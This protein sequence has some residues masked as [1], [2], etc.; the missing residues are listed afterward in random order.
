MGIILYY[1]LAII[2]GFA[3]Q[4][5][6]CEKIKH[7]KLRYSPTYLTVIG[8]ILIF[9]SSIGVF[10]NMG[11]SFYGG[12]FVALVFA[13]FFLPLTIGILSA[14]IFHF[15]QNRIKRPKDNT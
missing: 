14:D 4:L 9:L 2:A 15:V 12:S 1:L 8:W 11:D 10:G 6:L 13:V 7:T 5:V 3:L